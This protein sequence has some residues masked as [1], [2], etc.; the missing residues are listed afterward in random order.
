MNKVIGCLSAGVALAFAC[1]S[2]SGLAAEGNQDRVTIERTTVGGAKANVAPAAEV[3]VGG[4]VASAQD[5]H[6][7]APAQTK[8]TTPEVKP[9]AEAGPHKARLAVLPAIFSPL[10]KPEI[11]V[12]K[13]L[14][15]SGL[16]SLKAVFTKSHETHWEAP[17]LGL[18]LA[19]AFVGSRKFD[20]LERARLTEVLKEIQFGESEYAD[21]TRVV[22]LGKALN[23]EYVVLPS[24]EVVHL[25]EEIK[26]IPYVDHV[27]PRLLGKMIAR[28]QVVDTATSKIVAA[29]TDEVQVERRQKYDN[30]FAGSEFNSLVVDLYRMQSMRMLARTLEAI[31]PVRLLEATNGKAVLNRG[32][33]AISAGD[34]FDVYT[35]GKAYVDPDTGA[36]LGQSETKIARVKV[37]RVLPKFSEAEVVEGGDRLTGDLKG[38]LCRETV[39][40]IEAKTKVA[41][42]PIAW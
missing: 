23:A 36:S 10:F 27:R 18:S 28:L 16:V 37:V 34:E 35:L 29:F 39:P 12:A 40:S 1:L 22:P 25:V 20:V 8:A 41:L 13:T 31:Y 33:G 4:T 14:E 32:E 19:E 42:T 30:P 15:T 17:S 9:M 11:K 5:S 38:Y 3:T 2:M 7:A 26:D 21:A 24:I 6:E